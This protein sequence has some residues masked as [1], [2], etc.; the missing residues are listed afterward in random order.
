[1]SKFKTLFLDIETSPN[2]VL[3]WGLGKS[4]L[5]HDQLIKERQI[6]CISYKWNYEDKVHTLDWG[7]GQNDKKLLKKI[8]KIINA[9]DEIVA[10]NGDAFDIQFI[11]GRLLYHNLDP[12]GPLTT[13]D[14][15]KLSKEVFYLNSQK[16]DYLAQ[17]MNFGKKAETG[18]FGLW[19]SVLMDNCKESLE[20]M[21]KYCENDV[22]LLEKIHSKIVKFNPKLNKGLALTKNKTSCRNCGSENTIRWG[23]Y[24]TKAGGRFYRYRCHDCGTMYRSPIKIDK[25]KK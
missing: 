7:K 3:T 13:T 19:K 4:Y 24:T 1:M 15:L 11:N 10:H 2:M 17:Y 6:I 14:T 9:A 23:I 12:L 16:L 21:K 8:S 25:E 22:I 18:G 5:S 20:K